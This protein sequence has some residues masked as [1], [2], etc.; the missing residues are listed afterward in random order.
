[1]KGAENIVSTTIPKKPVQSIN[2]QTKPD[3]S[4]IVY[5]NESGKIVNVK[6]KDPNAVRHTGQNA[7]K[8][9]R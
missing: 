5:A 7:L 8:K 2:N 9:G 3:Y 6:Y 1:M 4:S